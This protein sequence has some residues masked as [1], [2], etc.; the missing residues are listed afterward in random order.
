M[1]SEDKVSGKKILL[2]VAL[3]FG[4]TYAMW[5]FLAWNPGGLFAYGSTAGMV[6]WVL[7]VLSPAIVMFVLVKKWGKTEDE[8][9]YFKAIFKTRYGWKP[10]LAETGIFLIVCLVI[11]IESA[12][13]IEPWYM[14]AVFFP[15][16]I[17][18]GGLE[19]IGWRGFLQPSLEKKLP[20]WL[21]API[22]GVVWGVW[23]LP[24][25]FIPGT[26]QS[27]GDVSF[28]FYIIFTVLMSYILGTLKRLTG[29]VAACIALHAWVN[30]LIEVFALAPILA[31][32]GISN[33]IV[34]IAILAVASTTVVY[35]V[36][37]KKSG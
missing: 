30:V 4:L 21:A 11:A 24:L 7:G 36:D 6:P 33:F 29:S 17:V 31:A 25:W 9:V 34:L 12:E 8:R 3:T 37:R 19:E 10:A 1:V 5:W 2:Y 14:L 15:V 23:H 18:G 20:F 22:V 16:M 35:I 28:P 26:F 32:G 27:S 13:R